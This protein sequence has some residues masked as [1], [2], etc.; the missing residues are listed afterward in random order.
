MIT[1]DFTLG[2][3]VNLKRY[4]RGV[5]PFGTIVA[6]HRLANKIE[7]RWGSSEGT[8]TYNP[9]DLRIGS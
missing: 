2:Q 3:T 8:N 1:D 4:P 7:V 5:K 9:E 6:V